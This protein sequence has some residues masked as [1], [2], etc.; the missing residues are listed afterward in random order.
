MNKKL[1]LA[2]LILILCSA[3][4]LCFARARSR[5][6]TYHHVQVVDECGNPVT[7]IT[8]VSIYKGDGSVTDANAFKDASLVNQI[9]IPMTTSSTNTTLSNGSFTWWGPDNYSCLV[10]DGEF[11]TVVKDR[12]ASTNRIVM[13]KSGT[14]RRK[15]TIE[16]FEKAPIVSTKSSGGGA[17]T[18]TGGDENLMIL[19]GGWFEYHI[20]GTQTILQPALAATGL[21]IG[22]DQAD[23][24]GVEITQGIAALD[25]MS[26]TVGTDPAFFVRVQITIAD[27]DGANDVVVGF[28]KAEAYQ[29]DNEAYDEL[30]SIGIVSD[31][32]IKTAEILNNATTVF[33]DTT[34]DWKD[35]ETHTLQVNISAAGVASFLFDGTTP[36]AYGSFT[37][38]DAEEVVPFI[39]L[40]HNSTIAGAVTLL[41]YEC[42]HQ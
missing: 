21:D 41:E 28:R 3:A 16:L 14:E 19:P 23:G 29:A 9:T 13:T 38:D 22:M 5:G 31:G 18:G 12:N 1:F 4:I 34:W 10:T 11:T 30:V 40:A 39:Y 33:T 6:Y 7:D 20:I 37:F 24:D 36:P 8:S 27:V 32:T 25:P 42:G 2:G 26:F 15:H 35:T 17:A